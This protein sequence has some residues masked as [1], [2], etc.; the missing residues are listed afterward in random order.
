MRPQPSTLRFRNQDLSIRSRS[1]LTYRSNIGL[2]R[3]LGDVVGGAS[4]IH[5]RVSCA[6]CLQVTWSKG[7]VSILPP[8]QTGFSLRLPDGTRSIFLERSMQLMIVV[9]FLPF[10]VPYRSTYAPSWRSRTLCHESYEVRFWGR[11][12]TYIRCGALLTDVF[13]TP[14]FS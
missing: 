4:T 3:P 7:P 1:P 5:C 11:S 13:R 8:S 14:S 9:R 10:D 12:E 6:V 2:R